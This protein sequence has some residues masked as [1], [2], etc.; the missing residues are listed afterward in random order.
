MFRKKN[1]DAK[2]KKFLHSHRYAQSYCVFGKK[3]TLEKINNV[4]VHLMPTLFST[5]I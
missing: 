5:I 2:E 1:Q 4:L 3:M